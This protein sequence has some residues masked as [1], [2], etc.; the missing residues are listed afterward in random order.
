MATSEGNFNTMVFSES[1]TNFLSK[2]QTK[3]L[4]IKQVLIIKNGAEFLL[5][6]VEREIPRSP[7]KRQNLDLSGFKKSLKEYNH[8]KY[9]GKNNTDTIDSRFQINTSKVALN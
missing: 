4:P 5:N 3:F 2:S 7:I 8:S 6:L 1:S 9:I